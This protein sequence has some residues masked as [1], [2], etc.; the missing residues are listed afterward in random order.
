MDFALILKERK[1]ANEADRLVLVGDLADTCG[2]ICHAADKL[3]DAGATEVYAI[4]S[5]R[6]L[7]PTVTTTIPREEEMRTCPGH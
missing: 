6:F 4:K 5:R 1:K 2:T 3:I 7:A